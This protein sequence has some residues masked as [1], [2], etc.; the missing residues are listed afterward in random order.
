M[1]RLLLAI[2]LHG[3][4]CGGRAAP[5]AAVAAAGGDAEPPAADAG[6][7][8][9]PLGRP[10]DAPLVLRF[11]YSL[12]EELACSE[13]FESDGWSARYEIAIDPSGGATLSV[14]A[15]RS[16]AFGPSMARFRD[17]MEDQARREQSGSDRSWRGVAEWRGD[18]LDLALAPDTAECKTLVPGKGWYLSEC[19]PSPTLALACR[20]GAVR[21]LPAG[22][23]ATPVDVEVLECAPAYGLPP[24]G[25]LDVELPDSLPFSP[26]PGLE[27]EYWRHGIGDFEAPKLR[28]LPPAAADDVAP[29]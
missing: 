12:S 16:H 20:R 13:S 2:A 25:A 29:E 3:A 14:N 26:P 10:T 18:D 5:P 23:G 7:A 1:S 11:A 28:A 22:G 9:D 21:A 15:D 24:P 8:P 27:L 19:R 4:A 17:D 6:P